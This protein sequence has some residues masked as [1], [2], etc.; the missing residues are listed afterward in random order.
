M[1]PRPVPATVRNELNEVRRL[2][3]EQRAAI[4]QRDEQIRAQTVTLAQ[5]LQRLNE[6][7]QPPPVPPAPVA[8]EVPALAPAA[9]AVPNPHPPAPRADVIV[10]EPVYERFRCQKP[11]RFEGTL[12]PTTAEEWIKRLQHI[13]NYMGLT[14]MERVA[15][16]ANQMDKQQC[17][18]GT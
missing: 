13:F 14:D 6:M 5:V 17:V 2:L 1:P 16:A 4:E 9:P 3:D 12:D 7:N 15:C 18:G 11:P 10:G 8:P